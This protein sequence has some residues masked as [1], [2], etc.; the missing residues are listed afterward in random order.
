[1]VQALFYMLKMVFWT[2]HHLEESGFFE[3]DNKGNNDTRDC[4]MNDNP[5]D[6]GASSIS[7]TNPNL[8][9]ND[10]TIRSSALSS[11]SP[12]C[13]RTTTTRGSLLS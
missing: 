2:D 5:T 4:N 3:G 10:N 7:I 11:P 8:V 9:D 6:A 1:M 12:V 13:N